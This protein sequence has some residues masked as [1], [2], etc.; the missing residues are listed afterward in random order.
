MIKIS[1]IIPCFNAQLFLQEC[2]ESVFRDDFIG[3]C[4]VIAIDDGSSDN[5]ASILKD[6]ALKHENLIIITQKNSG[7][8]VA[9]NA[10]LKVA[11]GEFVAFLDSDDELCVGSLEALYKKAKECDAQI[12]IGD[13]FIL[14][15]KERIEQKSYD[16]SAN[17]SS[18]LLNKDEFFKFFCTK[19]AHFAIWAK[20]YRKNLL[21]DL[22]FLEGVFVSEDVLFNTLAFKKAKNIT[23]CDVKVISYRVG[24]N[25]SSKVFKEKHFSDTL[26]VAENLEALSDD[27]C[28]SALILRL[29]YE[30]MLNIKTAPNYLSKGLFKAI[31]DK[32]FRLLDKKLKLQIILRAFLGK[33]LYF[34]SLNL[35]KKLLK[36]AKF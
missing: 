19:G 9:R 25:N 22:S 16:F 17:S 28:I 26:K 1:L 4:E 23:K 18:S 13:F 11:K 35:L 3:Q 10:G 20:L 5:T 36:K 32:G 12:V 21:N 29:K 24:Q 2:L 6:F 30:A 33:S 31:F 34:F 15:D 14:Q 8:S 7:A 27:I